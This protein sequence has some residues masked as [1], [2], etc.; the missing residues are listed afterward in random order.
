MILWI[1]AIVFSAAAI[2]LALLSKNEKFTDYPKNTLS[3]HQKYP[4]SSEKLNQ[5]HVIMI[6][7]LSDFHSWTLEQNIIYTLIAGSLIG[8]YWDQSIIPWD[9]D[10]D[11]LVRP[12]D[13][14][15]FKRLW[16][17]GKNTRKFKHDWEIT[18]IELNGK[19]YEMFKY[20][21]RDGWFKIRGITPLWE[22]DMGGIDIGFCTGSDRNN[23]WESIMG[24]GN[25]K[26]C[27]GPLDSDS[28][29]LFPETFLKGGNKKTKTRIID[30]KIGEQY[31]DKA[32]TKK[33]RIKKHP[34]LK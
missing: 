15:K 23:A 30:R 28:E 17:S 1:F 32:Y 12:K 26:S 24:D 33:W 8:Y 7:T 27:P 20:K 10:M 5:L 11:L 3:D 18:N 19:A 14:A 4:V 13:W 22:N 16:N 9:D 25:D 21:F 34:S 31:L 6:E 29:K 2:C